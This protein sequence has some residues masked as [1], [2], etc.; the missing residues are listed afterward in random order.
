MLQ[1][2]SPEI[3]IHMAPEEYVSVEVVGDAE[4]TDFGADPD[5]VGEN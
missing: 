2:L 3:L 1:T 5:R 4:E